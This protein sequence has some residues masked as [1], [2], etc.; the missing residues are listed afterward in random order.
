MAYAQ[1]S[2]GPSC[3]HEDVDDVPPA[4]ADFQSG[5]GPYVHMCEPMASLDELDELSADTGFMGLP[6]MAPVMPDYSDLEYAAQ[7]IQGMYMLPHMGGTCIGASPAGD[8]EAGA[9]SGGDRAGG[10]RSAS[11]CETAAVLDAGVSVLDEARA[12]LN[13][14]AGPPP[15]GYAVEEHFTRCVPRGRLG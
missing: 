8:G 12:L 11:D 15:T 14:N 13:F 10:G 3:E 2:S 7:R 9:G 1:M 6:G 5:F 4:P